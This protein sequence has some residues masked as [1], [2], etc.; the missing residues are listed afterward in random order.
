MIPEVNFPY[1]PEGKSFQYVDETNEY[2]KLAKARAE[3]YSY[4]KIMPCGAVV[5]KGGEIFG[6]GANGSYY[7]EIEGCQRVT[8]GCKTGECYELCEGCGPKNHS[9]RRALENAREKGLGTA[10]ADLYLWGNWWCCKGCWDEIIQAGIRNVFLL[11]NSEILF[12]KEHPNNIVGK[13]FEHR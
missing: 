6:V 11:R 5:V 3:G 10:G 4:D 7:H 9:E 8:L 13:L 1:L 12:N 2:M